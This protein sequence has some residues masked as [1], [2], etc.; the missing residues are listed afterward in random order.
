MRPVK[1]NTVQEKTAQFT[2]L[3]DAT[4]QAGFP[5]PAGDYEER[6][7]D[8]N[9]LLVR[10]PAST[11]CLRVEG[12]SMVNS[13]IHSGDILVVDRMLEPHHNDIVVANIDNDFVLK[14]F[15][16]SENKMLLRSENEN[17]L[18][19]EINGSMEFSIFGVVCSVVKQLRTW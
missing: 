18:D 4:V 10:H 19:I 15:I 2:P 1:V 14:R 5:S 8:F 16:V 13:G 6:E 7:L 11:F 17:F 3:L 12:D 9:T